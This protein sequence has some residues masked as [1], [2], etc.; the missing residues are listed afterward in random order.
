MRRLSPS[1]TARAELEELLEQGAAPGENLVSSF[2]H[3][4]ARAVAQELLEAEQ[5]D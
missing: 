5:T 2:V 1:V 3:L 4:V